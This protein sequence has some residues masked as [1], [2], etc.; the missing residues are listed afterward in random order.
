MIILINSEPTKVRSA[1]EWTALPI[2]TILLTPTA[3]S[4]L[5][6]KLRAKT[7]TMVKTK[8]KKRRWRPKM[9]HRVLEILNSI[10]YMQLKQIGHL[11]IFHAKAQI[12]KFKL[13]IPML[14]NMKTDDTFY[15]QRKITFNLAMLKIWIVDKDLIEGLKSLAAMMILK[16]ILKHLVSCLKLTKMKLAAPLAA[17]RT[18]NCTMLHS[19]NIAIWKGF[20]RQKGRELRNIRHKWIISI[21][22]KNRKTVWMLI[23]LKKILIIY[24]QM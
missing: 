10:N 16:L 19:R 2:I 20:K 9:S 11:T 15:T 8:M 22:K 3:R 12:F 14:H 13:V 17:A 5:F 4:K 6:Y 21:P 23:P 7:A 1:I 24:T 18:L